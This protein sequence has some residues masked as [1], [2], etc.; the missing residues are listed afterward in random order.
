MARRLAVFL[1][2]QTEDS[3]ARED[4]VTDVTGREPAVRF[5]DYPVTDSFD[6]NW[7]ARCTELIRQCRGTV[8]LVGRT[9]YQSTPVIWEIAETV[10][11][12]LPVL[13]VRLFDEDLTQAPVGLERAI[14]IPRPD[15]GSVVLRLRAW[16]VRPA[17]A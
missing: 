6:V 14:L 15:V 16:G 10:D 12:G 9:T 7:K 5:F 4:F 3:A 11:S 2:Y 17:S 13:G 1:S 8:V